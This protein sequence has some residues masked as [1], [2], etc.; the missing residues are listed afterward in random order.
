MDSFVSL[1]GRAS[2]VSV[3]LAVFVVVV[4]IWTA[5]TLLEIR[6]LEKLDR[7]ELV[8]LAEAESSDS[9]QATLEGI[10]FVVFLTSA[11]VSLM[12]IHRASKNLRPL[13]AAGQRF[14]PGWA[15]GWW[16]VPGA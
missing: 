5:S 3:L 7:G 13:G 9:R 16:F 6:L 11:I 14:S 2:L 1:R 4:L 15:I 8:T 12:W 10:Y